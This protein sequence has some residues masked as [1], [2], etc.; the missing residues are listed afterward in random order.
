MERPLIRDNYV[1]S[2]LMISDIKNIINDFI[3]ENEM[4]FEFQGAYGMGHIP[5]LEI[6]KGQIF[7]LRKSCMKNTYNNLFNLRKR[8]ISYRFY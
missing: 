2:A 7:I 3:D 4:E 5:I 6:I 1:P 8:G